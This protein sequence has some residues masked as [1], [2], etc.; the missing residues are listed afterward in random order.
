MK[1][2]F[3]FLLFVSATTYGQITIER[4]QDSLRKNHLGTSTYF[5]AFIGHP[6]YGL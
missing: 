1:P 2:I 6:G 3:I 5:D 4:A